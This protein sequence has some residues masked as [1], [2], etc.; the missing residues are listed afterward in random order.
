MTDK[1]EKNK[2]SL[3]KI[4]F[5]GVG[6]A[7][8]VTSLL[9]AAY[10][11]SQKKTSEII[12]PGGITYIG[13]KPTAAVPSPLPKELFTADSSVSW[14]RRKGFQ[15]PYSFSFPETLQLVVFPND[16]S[17]SMAIVWKD[18]PPQQNILINVELIKDR[19]PDLVGKPK[20]Y[21]ENWYKHFSGLKGVKSIEQF[22]NVNGIRGYKAV[23]TNKLDQTPVVDYFF[24]PPERYDIVVHMANGII[25]PSI[26]EKMI[27]SFNWEKQ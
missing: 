15:Y 27:N 21:I 22:K 17:D 20:E 24:I 16:P 2:Y 25:D 11:Y 19:N 14:I 5:F 18:F 4:T 23:Y 6:T 12:V 8:V 13:A 1:T 26:F 3:S 9:Y 10:R 7:V